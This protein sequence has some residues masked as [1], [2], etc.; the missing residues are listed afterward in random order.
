MSVLF[1]P[2]TVK[3]LTLRNR[4]VM[5]PMCQYSA[6]TNGMPGS[7]HL[8][9]YQSRAVGGTG[10]IILEATAVEPIGRISEND[11]GLWN[12]AQIEPLAKIVRACK[13]NG[14]CVGIQ[15]AHAGRKAI[16]REKPVAPSPL[17]FSAEHTVPEELTQAEIRGI[18]SAFTDAA[19]RAEAAGFDMIEIHGAHGYLINEFLSP[20]AN[21][22][23]DTYGG[24]RENRSRFL[25]EILDSVRTVWPEDK[26][27]SVRVS[28]EEYDPKGNHPD[29]LVEILTPFIAEGID[30]VH[31]SSGGVLPAKPDQYP[32]YQV[33]YADI[34]HNALPAPVIAGG[35]VTTPE[36]A[37][38]IL[39]NRRAD[40][41]FL[42]RELLRNPYWP[43]TAAHTLGVE[44]S[45]P[46]QYLRAKI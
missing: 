20:L 21:H 26:P 35:M 4:V 25:V 29:D 38:E 28:A 46:A 2:F 31:V 34:I 23:T 32:G 22:R 14:A 15:L 41:V 27:V 16:T 33:R 11:L 7:W 12:D 10:L 3:N 13:E 40:L 6:D 18:I 9:H 5:P 39:G 8:S 17:A 44:I 24:S 19:R 43:L 1:S 36:M 30:L 42:G 45:W 37:E